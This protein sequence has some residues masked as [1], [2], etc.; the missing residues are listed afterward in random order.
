MARLSHNA[1]VASVLWLDDDSGIISLGEDGMI[2]RWNRTSFNHWTWAKMVDI[3]IRPNYQEIDS[4]MCLA[5]FKDRVAVSLPT[6]GVKLWVWSKGSWQAQQPILRPN[7]TALTFIEGGSTL[8]GGT[9]DG[10]LWACEVPN[11]IIRA[12]AFL[13]T[14]I[15]S[16]DVNSAKTHALI[17]E[18]LACHGVSRLI[19]L[20]AEKRGKL[21]QSYANKDT[22]S[23]PHQLHTFACFTARGQGVLFGDIKGCALIWDTK[24]GTLVYG[25]DHILGEEDHGQGMMADSFPDEA[26]TAAAVLTGTST[27]LLSWWSQPA[28]ANSGQS[29]PTAVNIFSPTLTHLKTPIKNPKYREKVLLFLSF[30]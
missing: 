3:G 1:R 21:E 27:G 24:K 14:K 17:G 7:V 25:L 8:L 5:Y 29:S 23:S 13:K 10:V 16:I 2:S 28:Y 30:L 6:V 15:F 19:G 9:V 26:V 18:H 20:Q 12:C 11:G 22:E 4:G